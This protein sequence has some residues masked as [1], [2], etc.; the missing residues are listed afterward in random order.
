MRFKI[1]LVSSA[2]LALVLLTAKLYLCPIF[3]QFPPPSGPYSVGY[4][5]YHWNNNA[6]EPQRAEFNVSAFYP[7]AVPK[8]SQKQAAYHPQKMNALAKIAAAD[9]LV[10]AFIWRCMLSNMY[11]YAKPDAKIAASESSYPIILYLPGIGGTDLHNL[12]L[13]ELASH[14]YVRS[15]LY[16]LHR[17]KNANK[18]SASAQSKGAATASTA[19]TT[20]PV[21]KTVAGSAATAAALV[22]EAYSMTELFNNDDEERIAEAKMKGYEGDSCSDCG[23]FTLVRNGTCLKCVTCGSTSGCS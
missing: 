17:N 16:V 8:E 6:L 2:T 12:Y 4:L 14:G 9:S 22:E 10:P 7:S 21:Y 1:A 19:T 3:H 23:N 13:E 20:A 11:S 5:E 18:N 15:N